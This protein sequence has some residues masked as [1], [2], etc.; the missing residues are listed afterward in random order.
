MYVQTVSD[1]VGWSLHKYTRTECSNGQ[2]W[3]SGGDDSPKPPQ[4]RGG[5]CVSQTVVAAP[6]RTMCSQALQVIND[7]DRTQEGEQRNWPEIRP[8][9]VDLDFG[10]K[11]RMLH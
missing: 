3:I 10:C 4:D 9:I 1:A 5:V 7:W 6:D 2:W 11:R 8:L